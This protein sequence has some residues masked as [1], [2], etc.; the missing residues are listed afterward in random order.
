[1]QILLYSTLDP[2]LFRSFWLLAPCS[3]I[4]RTSYN[5]A[6]KVDTQSTY[7]AI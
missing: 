6:T 2:D 3:I 7:Q 1:M 5:I 4:N